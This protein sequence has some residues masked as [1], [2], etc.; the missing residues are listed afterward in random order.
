MTLKLS[1]AQKQISN[2]KYRSFFIF[3]FVFYLKPDTSSNLPQR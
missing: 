1:S 3:S 2:G